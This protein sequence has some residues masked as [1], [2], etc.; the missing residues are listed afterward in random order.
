MA[1]NY[2]RDSLRLYEAR[3][4]ISGQANAWN[5]IGIV[6]RKE[7]RYP[8]ALQ[9]HARALAIRERIGDPLGIGTSRNNLAQIELARGALDEAQ[10]D[11]SAALKRWSSIGYAAGVALARTGL[12]ITAVRRGDAETGRRELQRA[13]AE[14]GELGSR[15]YQSETQR[16]LAEAW[17]PTDV[18]AALEWAERAVAS[19]RAV[20]AA[21]QEGIALQVLG[22]VH[23]SRGETGDSLTALERSREILRG[24]SERHELGRTLASLARGYRALSA[25]DPRRA[26]AEAVNAQ[27]AA[28]FRELGAEVDLQRLQAG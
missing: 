2:Y 18:A 23:A 10:A 7:G 26:E 13:I 22:T 20:Q 19:A 9:A 8:D 14:W 15:T 28:I 21:D 17:L 12:G 16:Y 3:E 5:N 4:D 11:F 24:T 25:G 27:A 6:H 1:I